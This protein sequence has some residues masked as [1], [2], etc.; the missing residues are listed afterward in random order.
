M[1][2]SH[3]MPDP[4]AHARQLSRERGKHAAARGGTAEHFSYMCESRRERY[5]YITY[6]INR[7]PKQRANKFFD[8][9]IG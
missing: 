2:A 5:R 9:D 3:S 8:V 4:H 6:L 7:N 1:H